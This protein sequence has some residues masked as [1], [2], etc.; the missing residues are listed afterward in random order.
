MYISQVCFKEKSYKIKGVKSN[1]STEHGAVTG[2]EDAESPSTLTTCATE[3][4]SDRG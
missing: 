1:I 4:A 3:E 2:N